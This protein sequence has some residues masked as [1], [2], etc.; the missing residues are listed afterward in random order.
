M[1]TAIEPKPLRLG[2][3]PLTASLLEDM[4]HLPEGYHIVGVS[5]DERYRVLNFTLASEQLPEV[6]DGRSLPQLQL[7]VTYETWP[8]APTEY[9]K[10]TTEVKLQ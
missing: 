1:Q 5:Y 10:I 6:Q 2:I 4:Y 7:Y 3:L 9:R 8:D